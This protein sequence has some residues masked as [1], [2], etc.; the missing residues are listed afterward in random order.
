MRAKALEGLREAF[1]EHDY[2]RIARELARFERAE[3]R[4]AGGAVAS[5]QLGHGRSGVRHHPCP[6]RGARLAALACAHD[7]QR[8]QLNNLI[9][10]VEI[11]GHLSWDVLM[12]K[13]PFPY[14]DA[15]KLRSL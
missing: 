11:I 13:G 6:S 15:Q 7:H 3:R 9:P 8:S 5:P 14:A 2:E 4:P 1:D 12:Q 10:V